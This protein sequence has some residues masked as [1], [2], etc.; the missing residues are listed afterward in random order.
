MKY[1]IIGLGNFGSTLSVSLAAMGHEVIGVDKDMSKVNALKDR[2]THA[3][4]L[5]SSDVHAITTL[6]LKDAD[7]VIVGIGEDFGAAIMTTALLK[8]LKVKKL[9]SRSSSELNKTVVEAIG[10]D[11]IVSP[12]EESAERLAKKLQMEGVIDSFTI[13]ENYSIIEARVPRRYVGKTL[14]EADFRERYNLNVLTIIRMRPSTN[15]FGN[16]SLKLEVLGVLN[17]Q[18]R[19]LEDDILVLF[20]KPN[21]IKSCLNA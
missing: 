20:G 16:A 13:S 9:I 1:I 3:V 21:D 19:L 15:M 17:P 8:H 10:V 11:M 18:T 14:E 6:P 4:C 5:D 12:E 2:I 7:V